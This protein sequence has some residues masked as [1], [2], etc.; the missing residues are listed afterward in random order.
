MDDQVTQISE[1]FAAPKGNLTVAVDFGSIKVY[2]SPTLKKNFLKAMTKTSRV[3]PVVNTIAKLMMKNEFIPCYLTNKIYKTLLK[4]QPP[5][6]KGTVGQT[7]GK[8]IL[9]YV[10][11]EANIFGFASN[12]QLSITTLHELIHRAAGKFPTNFMQTFKVELNLFYSF[13]WNTIFSIKKHEMNLKE[14]QELVQFLF[15]K[16]KNPRGSNKFLVEYYKRLIEM[17]KDKTTLNN[18]DFQKLV[19]Q[20]IVMIKIIWKGELAGLPNLVEKAVFANKHLIVPFY[21][22]Y[23]SVFGINVKHIKELCYQE[24][25]DPSEVIS[26]PA[27]VKRPSQK[28]YKMINKM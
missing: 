16:G 27:L 21:T 14:V 17:F 3:A 15:N 24:L 6:L 26:L 5:S 1:L 13:Y 22:T 19:T 7:F 10:D 2:T 23:K 25:Y 12:N 28:V 9:V 11:N 4:K 18:E 8:L 20:Y